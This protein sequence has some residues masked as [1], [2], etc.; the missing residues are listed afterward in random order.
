MGAS[1]HY[2]RAVAFLCPFPAVYFSKQHTT[3]FEELG[4]QLMQV[5]E[6]SDKQRKTQEAYTTLQ[7]IFTALHEIADFLSASA[8][9]PTTLN[10]YALTLICSAKL[11]EVKFPKASL[12]LKQWMAQ[13]YDHLGH[14]YEGARYLLEVWKSEREHS[15][16]LELISITIQNGMTNLVQR[17]LTNRGL[18][19]C[20]R[21]G[22]GIR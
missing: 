7:E 17:K 5:C 21:G 8:A 4:R 9:H 14:D 15:M 16:L 10:I 12:E 13:L 18:C 3:A 11:Q 6:W 19:L 1:S 22:V 20:Q 2:E